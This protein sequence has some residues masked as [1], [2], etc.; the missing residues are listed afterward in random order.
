MIS[1][2]LMLR[3]SFVPYFN[4]I[5]LYNL[6]NFIYIPQLEEKPPIK[7]LPIQVQQNALAKTH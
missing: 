4:R 7:R 2:D 3:Y 5:C 6:A 1:L